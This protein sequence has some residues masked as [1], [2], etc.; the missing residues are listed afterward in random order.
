M[1][2]ASVLKGK[3]DFVATISPDS[4]VASLLATLAQYRIGAVVVSSDG[5]SMAGM[6]SERDVAR[7]LTESGSVILDGPVSQIMSSIV[8]TCALDASVEDVM[9]QMTELR[10]RHVPVIDEDVMV[11]IVSIGDVVKAR[12]DFLEEERKSLLN[13]ITS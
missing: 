10:V 7:A 11:G 8:A 9:V 5:Q 4:T 3:G 2:I 13:Y 1:K 6:A 12:I